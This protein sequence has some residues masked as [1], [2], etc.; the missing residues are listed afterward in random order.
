MEKSAG[1]PDRG[2]GITLDG[3]GDDDLLIGTEA[4]DRLNGF[5]G[6]DRLEG[7]AG[8]D[9]LDGGS[10]NDVLLGGDGRDALSGGEGDNELDG[11][12]GDDSLS[13]IGG[14]NVLRGGA[15]NDSLSG[16]GLTNLLDGGVGNDNLFGLGIDTFVF[17]RRYG[18]DSANPGAEDTIVMSSGVL[19]A[20]V[21]LYSFEAW[22]H[23]LSIQGTSDELQMGSSFPGQVVFADG[24]V[25]DQTYLISHE[26]QGMGTDGNDI[27]GGTSGVDTLVGGEGDDLYGVGAGDIVIEFP[28]EG[29]DAITTL[30]DYALPENVENLI[31]NLN[32]QAVLGIGNDLD[33]V[34]EGSPDHGSGD[35]DNILDG[36]AGNDVLIGGASI[37]SFTEFGDGSDVLIGGPGNDVL[38]PFF[39]MAGGSPFGNLGAHGVDLLL[40]GSG[41][42][43][44]ILIGGYEVRSAVD[45]TQGPFFDLPNATVVELPGEGSDT[46]VAITD[47]TLPSNVENLFLFGGT[48][49]VGNELDNVLIGSIGANILEGHA[50]NDTLIGGYGRILL[51]NGFEFVDPATVLDD[52]INDGAV[53]RLV[54]GVGDDVYV[55]GS[56][57]II[58]ESVGEGTDKVVS[59]AS[60]Q[61]GDHL[62]YL[63]LAGDESIDAT[64]NGLDNRLTGNSAANVLTGA[65]GNDFLRGGSG[66]DTYLFNLGNGVDTIEDTVSAAEGNRVLF[67]AGIQLSDLTLT[68]DNA[69]H[70]L[71]IR[72]GSNGTDQLLLKNFDPTGTNGSLVVSTLAF[73]DGST[74][75]LASL[76]GVP[77]NHVPTV[78]NPLTDQIVPESAPFSLPVPVNTF[79]DPDADDLLTLNASLADGSALPSW[80]SF[81]PNAQTF[82]GTPDD[83]QIGNLDVL[84]TAT[85]SGNLS[86]SDV[87]MLTVQNVNEAPSVANPLANQ[88]AL[89]NAPFS[90][91]IP[92]DTFADQDTVHGDVLTYSATLAND[93]ALPAWLSFD[94]QTRT[95]SGTPGSGDA[96]VL[97]LK[98]TAT[99]SGSLNVADDFALTV[100]T[101]DQTLAGTAGNDV[102]TGGVGN[103]QLFGLAGNDTLTGGAG[104]DLLDGGPGVDNMQG[105]TGNDTYVVDASGD[106]VIENANKG[107]DGVQSS[108]T[109][110]LGADVE[111]LTLTGAANI[112]GTGNGLDNVLVG[113]NGSN[114]LTGGT[115]NDR[116]D[117]GLGN[118][119]MVGGTGDDTYVVNQ[120]GDVVTESANQGIDT[121]ESAVTYNLGSNVENLTLTGTANI[122]GTGSSVN[123]VLLGNS[124]NN[125]LDGG[126]GNDTV[127]GGAGNDV[128]QGGSG[129]DSLVGG[130]GDDTLTGG[131][132]NDVLD[133]GDGLDMLDGGS[134]NDILT[135]GA[136]NDSLTGGSGADQFTGGTGNDMLTGGSGNDHYMFAR[137][138]GQD[139]ISDTDSTSGN[140]DHVLFGETINPL[141]V[142]LSRHANDLRLAVY[143]STDQVTIQNWYVGATNQIETVQAGDGQ[144]LLNTQVEQLIQA[145]AA[146]TTQTGLTWE[147]GIAQQPQQVE[148]ILAASWH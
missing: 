44:Y 104:N 112:N 42:D 96:G 73:A 76:V 53:D 15:G 41:D 65:L 18:Y 87:F 26:Q 33:N 143:G 60:Y 25:W 36:G 27:M 83:A 98:V 137:G 107:T 108:I 2:P 20:D 72:V 67:G 70:T 124:G 79:A 51:P 10:G 46:V 77:A 23:R 61:L 134:G 97:N 142:V 48:H 58:V 111:N 121:V 132:G 135:G 85:D 144:L 129:D 102:L 110:T 125:Q 8:N 106:V 139:T 123:N 120:V 133:G 50:G 45:P 93:A 52:S 62:E 78:A 59:R 66:D 131:S 55:V 37:P 103:D 90:L 91:V 101:A 47:Q 81:D 4:N 105:G 138:D 22:N 118:D 7:G 63:M 122:N 145:M 39:W 109:Y 3:G 148:S 89:E 16:Q 34:I 100:S 136:G 32:S 35:G 71:T 11:G 84:V 126:S 57:D 38:R 113:N 14:Q 130:L 9:I 88:A 116:L 17:G 40:G 24:T 19:P 141:D 74:T 75:D 86:V 21:K 13:A 92:A 1:E 30:L 6:N 94:K 56:G 117:G 49:G 115:G 80:L 64:G 82:T 128:L 99:D 12:G 114:T 43:T 147:Q 29:N 28:N 146:F 5:A 69:A 119:T 68:Q 95:F 31:F 127:D 140:Q 54:G